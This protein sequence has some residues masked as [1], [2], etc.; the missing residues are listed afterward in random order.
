LLSLTL[1]LPTK[2]TTVQRSS[3]S[4]SL[5]FFQNSFN[6]VTRFPSRVSAID[7]S[8]MSDSYSATV[9]FH[10]WYVRDDDC[11]DLELSLQWNSCGQGNVKFA[12]LNGEFEEEIYMTHSNGFVVKSQ[13]DKVGKL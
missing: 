8:T 12:F 7:L 11:A 3:F 9:L 2:T 6:R 4:T 10:F 13:E 1:F 5:S